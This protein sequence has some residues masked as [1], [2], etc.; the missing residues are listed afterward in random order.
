MKNASLPLGNPGRTRPLGSFLFIVFN[1]FFC[2]LV[3]ARGKRHF[4][5]LEILCPGGF[6]GGLPLV[7]LDV[8]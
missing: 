7:L 3:A 5:F 2:L 6:R 8:S 4:F 1:R